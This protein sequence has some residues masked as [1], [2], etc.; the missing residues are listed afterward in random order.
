MSADR[1]GSI[2]SKGPAGSSG[3]L[4]NVNSRRRDTPRPPGSPG[5]LIVASLSGAGEARVGASLWD[6]GSEFTEGE[7]VKIFPN[8]ALGFLRITVERPLRLRWEV[9]EETIEVAITAKALAKQSETVIALLRELLKE[10]QGSAFE[11]QQEVA[12][13]LGQ[14][15]T[16]VGLPAAGQ[17]ALMSGLA[18][19]DDSADMVTDRKGNPEPDSAS[20]RRPGSS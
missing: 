19:R 15:I 8:E 10:H 14:R 17:R 11:T 7:R 1:A 12:K 9:T 2:G 6:G 3:S 13:A 4:L 5:S 16:E 18:V 20:G